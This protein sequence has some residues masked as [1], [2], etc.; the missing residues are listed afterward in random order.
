M[1]VLQWDGIVSCLRTREF[2]EFVQLIED[3]A[4]I[5]GNIDINVEASGEQSCELLGWC[6][7]EHSKILHTWPGGYVRMFTGVRMSPS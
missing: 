3:A 7:R 1:L 6:F 4:E 5:E 2:S